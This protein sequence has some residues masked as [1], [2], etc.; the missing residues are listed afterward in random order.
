VDVII[1]SGGVGATHDDVTIRSVSL[2]LNSPLVYH[3]ELGEFIKKRN[4]INGTEQEQLT[5][6]QIKMATLPKVSK[7]RFL[8]GPNECKFG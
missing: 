3:K 8:S 7:L 6:G 4:N 2:A 1:T 5:P